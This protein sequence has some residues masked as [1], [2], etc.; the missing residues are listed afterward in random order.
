ME[1][2]H[3]VLVLG[4]DRAQVADRPVAQHDVGVPAVRVDA[5]AAAAPLRRAPGRVDEG[6]AE[7]SAEGADGDSDVLPGSMA[8]A[9]AA[10]RSPEGPPP[11]SARGT[12]VSVVTSRQW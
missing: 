6:P 11:R 1:R 7:G 10:D 9:Y 5:E 8:A 12:G 4:A 3:G 2:L